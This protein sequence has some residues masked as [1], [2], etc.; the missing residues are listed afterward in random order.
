MRMILSLTLMLCAVSCAGYKV[1]DKSNPFA[2]Y[3]IKSISIPM[4][5]NRSNLALSTGVITESIVNVLSNFKG[6]KIYTGYNPNADAVLLGVV[7]S[8]QE[9]AES[10]YKSG[11]RSVKNTY[12]DVVDSTRED[13]YLPSGAVVRL[14]LRLTIIKHPSEEEIRFLQSKFGDKVLSSKIVFNETM[15]LSSSYTNKSF[16]ASG[17]AVTGTHNE[18]LKSNALSTIAKNAANTFRDIILYAF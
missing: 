7:G 5:Y 2:Q 14:S 11:N 1:L 12:G 10:I 4:F 9:L 15:A 18:Y 3:E 8:K 17:L 6:L 13:F 16:D